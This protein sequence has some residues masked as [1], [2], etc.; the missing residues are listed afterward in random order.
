[1]KINGN[2]AAALKAWQRKIL[3]YQPAKEMLS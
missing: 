1:M 3:Q 2:V